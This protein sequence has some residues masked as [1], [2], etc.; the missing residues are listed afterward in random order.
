[1][2]AASEVA[3]EKMLMFF[4]LGFALFAACTLNKATRSQDH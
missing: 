1:M 4:V 3:M 2:G